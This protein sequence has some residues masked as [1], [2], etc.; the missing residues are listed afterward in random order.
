MMR[1]KSF[2]H[3]VSRKIAKPNILILFNRWDCTDFEDEA[4]SSLVKEQH[5]KKACEF[6]VHELNV[7]ANVN[8]ASNQVYFVSAK[9]ALENQVENERSETWS[10]FCT[11]IEACLE[12]A[13]KGAK[14]GPLIDAGRLVAHDLDNIQSH[15]YVKAKELH[16][17][18]VQEKLILEE[19][20]NQIKGLIKQTTKDWKDQG[21]NDLALKVDE[22]V[23]N[24][25]KVEVE[26]ALP[27]LIYYEFHGTLVN[28]EPD[29][30]KDYKKNLWK[31]LEHSFLDSL[32]SRLSLQ[33]LFCVENQRSL[34]K[35]DFSHIASFGETSLKWPPLD[36]KP[37]G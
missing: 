12:M 30:I 31:H 3:S 20:L 36:G 8:D 22:L 5:L 13:G 6:L 33:L 9:E 37:W 14:F 7:A 28:D 2:F 4:K 21:K 17:E 15:I 10:R 26:D 16:E 1:E 23:S 35:N 24:A 25:F 11:Y 32:Q 34:F 29:M 19:K 27:N 18:K